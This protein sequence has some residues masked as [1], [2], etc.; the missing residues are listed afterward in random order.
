MTGSITHKKTDNIAAWTQT[1]LNAQIALGNFPAGTLITDIVLSTDWND[2]H[3]FNL[4]T[5]D[6]TA[7][8]NKNYVTDAQ[9]VVIGN[10]SGTNTGDQNL[11]PYLT[12]STAASTYVPQ[13]T[14]VNGH[15]LS[16]N[17]T[18]SASDVGSPS[19]S[20]TSTGTNTGDQTSVTGNA[21]TVTTIS[22][23]ITNG[24]NVT[25]SGAGTSVSPYSIAASSGSTST[26]NTFQI[27]QTPASGTYGTL[28]GAVNGSNT[29]FTVSNG[30]YVSGS[31]GA[32]LNGQMLT[33]GASNDWTETSPSSGTFTFS[34]APPTGSI[35]Q[36]E[37]IKTA[38][39]TGTGNAPV[40]L[41]TVSGIN[42]KTVANTTLYTVP[43]GKTATI[44]GA[45]VRCTA[46]S[47]ITSGP[48]AG[49]G[50]TSGTNNIFASATMTALTAVLSVFGYSLVG[51]SIAVAAGGS[52]FFN[53]GT[54]SSGTSQVITVDLMG[55]LA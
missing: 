52:V 49:I 50:Q 36:A 37:Y 10:T 19:G 1:D 51:M 46:A 29:V 22:G 45:V 21:G 6:V 35:V 28:A 4:T 26:I 44:T 15:A 38:T 3:T 14:T 16:G 24:A 23:L 32:V 48:S 13:T 34:I 11:A 47:S 7:S 17:V 55:Y 30:A 8:T 54:G 18:V 12:S 20:G 27:D 25:I 5:A 2:T 9:L 39:T 41:A 33:Q 43:V 42:A 40:I 31:L 53:I